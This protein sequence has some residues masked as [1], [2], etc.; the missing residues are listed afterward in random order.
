[1]LLLLLLQACVQSV[2]AMSSGEHV[3]EEDLLILCQLPD[4]RY[5]RLY[6]QLKDYL[7][8]MQHDPVLAL[9]TLG[10]GGGGG[11]GGGN[12]RSKKHPSFEA[13]F[14]LAQIEDTP[15]VRMCIYVTCVSC[16]QIY[17]YTCIVALE[18]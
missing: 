10:G 8:P 2:E 15:E 18:E 3:K 17:I 1:M 4:G 6:K 5:G 12:G 16:V 11:G 7:Q 13:L 9:L 14:T